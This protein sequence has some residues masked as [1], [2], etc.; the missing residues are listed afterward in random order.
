MIEINLDPESIGLPTINASGVIKDAL[1]DPIC[2][3]TLTLFEPN[4]DALYLTK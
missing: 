1:G 4:D 2:E 3:G